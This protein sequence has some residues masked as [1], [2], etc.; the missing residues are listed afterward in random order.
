MSTQ[1]ISAIVGS[2]MMSREFTAN[3]TDGQW[4]GNIL[5]DS[6]ASTNLGLV[7]PNQTIDTVQVQYSAGACIWRIQ[8]SQ[9]LLVKRYGYA[10]KSEY[11]C[12]ESSKIP[13]YK[14]A[15]DDIL[16][17]YPMPIA[18]TTTTNVLAWVQT[19]RGFE[20]FGGANI[21]QKSSTEIKTLVNQQSIGDYAF[22]AT[23]QGVTVQANDNK[24]ILEVQL[25]DQTGGL[26][27]RGKGGVRTPAAGSTQM[28]YNFSASGMGIPILKGYS[29]KVVTNS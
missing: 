14:V 6:V 22:N 12:W 9:T 21:A 18:A 11:G 3:A 19:S 13:A 27:W 4:S 24:K 29:L 23:L 1:A 26:I 16:T 5:V 25:F 20:A 8:S 17:V 28:Y 2:G 15:P 7:M 10:S